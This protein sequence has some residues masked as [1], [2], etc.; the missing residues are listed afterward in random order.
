MSASRKR[1]FSSF[2]KSQ[3][4]PTAVEPPGPVPSAN[5]TSQIPHAAQEPDASIGIGEED[6]SHGSAMDRAGEQEPPAGKGGEAPPRTHVVTPTGRVRTY[7]ASRNLP[8]VT[9]RMTENRWERLKMLSIQERRP[10]QEILGEA[11]Q[12]YMR[13]RGLPW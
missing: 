10:I 9:Y 8:G 13:R 3:P 6:K 12:D 2:V 1:S 4:Q 5:S 7:T 11:L